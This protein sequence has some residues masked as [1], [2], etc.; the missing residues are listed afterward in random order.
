TD[1]FNLAAANSGS[2]QFNLTNV[3][4]YADNGSGQPAGSPITSTGA[5]ASGATFKFIVS[6]TVPGTAA[7]T[8][9]NTIAVTG[10][11]TGDATK[12]ASNTDTT[13]ATSN[14]VVTLT[15]SI[16]VATG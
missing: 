7:N 1:T 16:S 10:T 2:P 14:A 8:Q 11:S 12:T 4:I 5:I 15:K 13:T 9:T 3:L 6:G